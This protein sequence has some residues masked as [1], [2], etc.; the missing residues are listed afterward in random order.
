MNLIDSNQ[1]HFKITT[2]KLEIN[3]TAN[4]MTQYLISTSLIGCLELGLDPNLARSN[5]K[6]EKRHKEIIF[7]R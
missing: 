3:Y 6:T 2:L 1:S 5:S 4:K 7:Y